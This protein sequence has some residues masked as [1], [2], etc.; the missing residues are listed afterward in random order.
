MSDAALKPDTQEIVVDEVFPH[1]PETL[2]KTLTTANLM[3]RWL[4]MPAG[5]EPV[6]GNRFTYR[7]TPAGAW[8]G[9]IHCQVLEVK[10][11]ERLSYAW[12][13]GHEGNAGYG[14]PLNT[15]VTFILSEVEAG[16]RL[17]LIHSGFVLPRNETAFQKMGEGWK[18]VVKNIG[19]IVDE[20]D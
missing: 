4:M 11:N 8:D 2:W 7:T 12:K 5:F 19:A 14:S 9:A 20:T 17:R 16:T 18:K 10:P 3:G 13:G 6:E 15:V 1:R